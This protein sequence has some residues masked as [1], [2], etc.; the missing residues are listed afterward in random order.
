[1]S[2]VKWGVEIKPKVADAE[3]FDPFKQWKASDYTFI[4][5]VPQ[6]TTEVCIDGVPV[7]KYQ[8]MAK[9]FKDA[10]RLLSILV[11]VANGISE[12]SQIYVH[13]AQQLL[14]R[15]GESND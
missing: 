10:T 6:I 15:L 5:R 8:D 7:K 12:S 1:M 2:F 14:A 11:D 9:D 4:P 13:E 3:P